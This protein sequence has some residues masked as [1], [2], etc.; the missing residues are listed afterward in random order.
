M[1]LVGNRHRRVEL[2]RAL[3]GPLPNHE[4]HLCP[5]P[6]RYPR[7]IDRSQRQREQT[8]DVDEQLPP[9]AIGG[10][11]PRRSPLYRTWRGRS[12]E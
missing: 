8:G 3:R 6:T 10:I 12:W 7:D 4:F 9:P 1:A 11:L 5:E 2:L